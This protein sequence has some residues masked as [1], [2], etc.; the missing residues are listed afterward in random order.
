MCGV[1]GVL[2]LR[3]NPVDRAVLERMNARLVHRG[4]DEEGY[5]FNGGAALAQRRLRIIDLTSGKQPMAN[6]DGTVWVTFN[7]EIYNF[8]ELRSDLEKAGHRFATQSDTEVIVHAYEQHGIECV[9]HFRGMFAFALWD[10]ARQMLLLARDRVGKKPLF[11]TTAGGQFIFASELQ[12]LVAHPD[13]PRD[14]DPCALDDYLTYGYIAA[15]A[16]IYRG[17]F[18]VPPAHVLTA[19][20]PDGGGSLLDLRLKRYWELPYLPKLALSEV[21]AIEATRAALT[22]AVRLRM[23]ADV[24]LGAHLS[25]GIDSSLVVALMSGL[26]RQPVKTFSIGFAEREYDELPYARMVAER[27]RTEH[28]ELVVRP[29]ALEALPQLVRHYGEPFA[30][31]SAVPS[32]YVAQMTRQHVTVALNGDGGDESFAG[33]ERYLAGHLTR[34]YQKIPRLIRCGVLEPLARLLP[35]NLPR[36]SWLRKGQRFIRDASLPAGQSYVG[37]I[38]MFRP[39]QKA[40]LY[41]PEFH[42]RLGTHDAER[43]VR[44]A[45]DA[46]RRAGLDPVDALLAADVQTYLPFD[47]LVKMDIATMAHSLEVRSPFLDHKVMELAARLPVSY[48]VRRSCLKYL[49]KQLGVDLLPLAVLRRPKMGFGVPV[50]DW[51]KCELRPLLDDALSA[52]RVGRRGYFRPNAVRE[53]VDA[54]GDGRQDSAFQLWALLCLELWHQEFLP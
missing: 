8:H 47:L 16:T 42:A 26:S 19:H 21:E 1:A 11:Y 53:L 13:V 32:Y 6:E 17:I 22:E 50:G 24:P 4:P 36:R 37:W 25:G 43:G 29:D 38:S 12:A 41:T 31:S 15:P 45:V 2:D 40:A 14:L 18:K 7:G 35:A 39:E 3:G 44:D 34:R 46:G 54:H 30:D 33:Y 27:F 48:K 9:Q 52:D 23:I 10:Q 5:Y 49:L 51:M 20:V 28:H